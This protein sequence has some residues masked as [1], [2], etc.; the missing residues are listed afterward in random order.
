MRT[1]NS[2]HGL[3]SILLAFA[4]V[5]SMAISITF[6]AP[7]VLAPAVISEPG[8]TTITIYQG[9]V[10]TVSFELEWDQADA[11]SYY[12]VAIDWWDNESRP[13]DNF[14][15]VS[16]S[17]VFTSGPSIGLS[18]DATPDPLY[19]GPEGTGTRYNLIVGNLTGD[20]RNGEF[21]VD[22]RF[23]AAGVGGVNHLPTD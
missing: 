21:D 17:A 16:A 13:N 12:A 22:V 4:L 2:T 15:F 9:Q 7:L 10:F 18:I 19:E 23:R 8:G 1:E 14:T 3:S 20:A 6:T 5:L 11:G